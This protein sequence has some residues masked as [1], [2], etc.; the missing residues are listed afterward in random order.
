MLK[1]GIVGLRRGLIGF[2]FNHFPDCRVTA[3]CDLDENKLQ[4]VGDEYGVAQRYQGFEDILDSDVDALFIA[5][6]MQD[7]A[8]QAAA[9]LRAGK[10]VLSEVN[11]G[12][13]WR[14]MWMLGE[15]AAESSAIYMLAEN[16]CYMYHTVLIRAMAEAGLFGEIYFAE[17]EYVH[18]TKHLMVDE[19]GNLTW[20]GRRLAVPGHNYPSHSLTP[21]LKIFKEPVTTVVAL[22]SG[23]YTEGPDTRDDCIMV[24][25]NTVSGKLIRLRYDVV[26]NRPPN[27]T[28]YSLQGS[29]G[30]YEAPRGLGDAHKVY[31]VGH[32]DHEKWRPLSEYDD[33]L[34]DWY[35]RE[36]ENAQRLG[37]GHGGSDYFVALEFYRAVTEGRQPEIDIWL[38]LNVSAVIPASRDSILAGGV[39]VHIPDFRAQ[40]LERAPR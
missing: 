38:A 13:T 11:A 17:G 33:Y 8:W 5:T 6:P 3:I 36:R 7:H 24:L 21:L 16:Y 29:K 20:R 22:G 28:Y 35:L 15:A 1:V 27:L 40:I 25:L 34:P 14:D 32:G 9:A 30:A 37:R 12:F 23:H 4:S 31:I 19:R 18:D 2:V 10:H 39:P 26:S